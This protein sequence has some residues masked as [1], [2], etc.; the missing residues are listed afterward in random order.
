MNRLA[1]SLGLT[2]THF[3]SVHG[4][5]N[6]NNFSTAKDMGQLAC[7]AQ[8]SELFKRVAS[9]VSYEARAYKISY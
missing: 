2:K 7:A 8:S 3:A 6:R 4:L 9:T 1:Q 5:A